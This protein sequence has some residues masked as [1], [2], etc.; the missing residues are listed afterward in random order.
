M[1]SNYRIRLCMIVTD[2]DNSPGLLFKSISEK[3]GWTW[4]IRNQSQAN[5]NFMLLLLVRLKQAMTV[6]LM[7]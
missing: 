2:V 4:N 1:A 6:P 7:K 3:I 5:L